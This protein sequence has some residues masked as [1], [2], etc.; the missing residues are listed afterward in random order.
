MHLHKLRC[1][2]CRKSEDE[3]SKLVAGPRSITGIRCYMCDGCIAQAYAIVQGNPPAASAALR[4]IPPRAKGLWRSLLQ[5]RMGVQLVAQI[6]PV[7][8]SGRAGKCHRACGYR[9]V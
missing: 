7:A 6:R 8:Y 2:F 3:V 4:S 1:S 9:Q 5:M